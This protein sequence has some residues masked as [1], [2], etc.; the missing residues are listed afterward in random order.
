MQGTTLQLSVSSLKDQVCTLTKNDLKSSKH[1]KVIWFL[2]DKL[3]RTFEDELQFC[4]QKK[5][6]TRIKIIVNEK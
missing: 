1:V 5:K 3:T 2:L 6:Q 4:T